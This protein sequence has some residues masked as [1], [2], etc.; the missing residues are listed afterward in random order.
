MQINDALK[1]DI[2]IDDEY[3]YKKLISLSLHTTG[4]S[5]FY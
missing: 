1:F 2:Y 4:S 5:P 3:P